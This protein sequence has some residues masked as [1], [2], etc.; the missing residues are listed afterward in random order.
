MQAITWC[1]ERSIEAAEGRRGYAHGSA[2]DSDNMVPAMARL[3]N[4]VE[5]DAACGDRTPSLRITSPAYYQTELRDN[6]Q[7]IRP[8]LRVSM[9]TLTAAARGVRLSNSY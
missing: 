1:D 7:N 4:P 3:K 2:W 6:K 9:D 5:K 8:R